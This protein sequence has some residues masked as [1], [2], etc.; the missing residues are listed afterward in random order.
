MRSAFRYR[1][2]PNSEQEMRLKRSLLLLCNLY[3]K[4]RAKKIQEHKQS[5]IALTRMG[6]RSM[7]LEERGKDTELRSVHSQVVQNTAD[8]LHTA[9][10]N[11]FEG[12]A[13]FPKNK[14]RR[15]YCSLTYPQSGFKM[16]DGRLFLSKIGRVRIFLHRAM[17]GAIQ[18]LTVKYEAG[19]WYAILIAEREPPKKRSIDRIPNG[20]IR[21]VDVG[22]ARFATL[23]NAE[24]IEYPNSFGSPRRRSSSYRKD[25]QTSKRARSA[26]RECA[27]HL[28][29]SIST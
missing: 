29:D 25:W 17:Q 26:G 1:I 16:Q 13:R 15:K 4:L 14:Q 12:R 20:R 3:N 23:D 6:L 24:S 9:F 18:R 2:Y 11:F 7:A 8:R 21:G 22:V 19:E 5:G 27:S 28:P 10:V